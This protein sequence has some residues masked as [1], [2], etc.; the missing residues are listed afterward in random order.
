[1]KKINGSLGVVVLSMVVGGGC[2]R[3]ECYEGGCDEE[4]GGESSEESTES[5]GS[6]DGTSEGDGTEEFDAEGG[7]VETEGESGEES[8]SE[9]GEEVCVAYDAICNGIYIPSVDNGRCYADGEYEEVSLGELEEELEDDEG[10]VFAVHVS[11]GWSEGVEL[12]IGGKFVVMIVSDVDEGDGFF[13][14]TGGGGA[15]TVSGGTVFVQGAEISGSVS[16]AE[17][18]DV[19]LDRVKLMSDGVAITVGE[20][21]V[22]V[23]RSFVGA[24]GSAVKLENDDARVS[25]EYSSVFSGG[26]GSGS[27]VLCECKNSNNCGESGQYGVVE[28]YGTVFSSDVTLLPGESGDFAC[29]PAANVESMAYSTTTS[30]QFGTPALSG[31]SSMFVGEGDFHVDVSGYPLWSIYKE[32]A[33]WSN[34][35]VMCDIDGDEIPWY[36]YPGADQPE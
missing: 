8:D 1:M 23:N 5:G 36:G 11:S 24:D 27:V 33:R 17:G 34:G 3:N 7:G 20:G 26:E 19:V 35:I 21:R 29:D 15:L 14:W 31:G 30:G 12:S 18:G 16:V 10:G 6:E 32:Y 13:T 9:G 28:S 4:L 22:F 2:A 25:F